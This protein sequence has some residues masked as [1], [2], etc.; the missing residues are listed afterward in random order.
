MGNKTNDHSVMNSIQITAKL[1]WMKPGS[2]L[3]Y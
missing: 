3:T 2:A 1:Y